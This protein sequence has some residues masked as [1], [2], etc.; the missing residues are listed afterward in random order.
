MNSSGKKSSNIYIPRE[1]EIKFIETQTKMIYDQLGQIANY[2]VQNPHSLF[3]NQ[4]NPK[5]P[6]YQRAAQITEGR[7]AA[8]E[9]KRRERLRLKE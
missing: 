5:L 8:L 9:E 3:L 7:E 2:K 4:K 1:K 6:I